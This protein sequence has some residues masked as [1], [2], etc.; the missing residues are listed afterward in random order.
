[1]CSCHWK[2]Y[3]VPQRLYGMYDFYIG[4]VSCLSLNLVRG[5]FFFFLLV[6]ISKPKPVVSFSPNDLVYVGR[7][8]IQMIA[9]INLILGCLNH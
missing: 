1:M 4:F 6:F 5:L 8:L 3:N 7:G 9:E 2:P